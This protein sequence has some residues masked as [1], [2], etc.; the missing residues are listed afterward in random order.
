NH[1]SAMAR[2]RGVA[3]V[4]EQVYR[5][6]SGDWSWRDAMADGAGEAARDLLPGSD[7]LRRLNARPNPTHTKFTVVAGRLSPVSEEDLVLL[8][9]RV[10]E[11]ARS[12]GM[13]DTAGSRVAKS[14]FREA[15]RG[16][17]DGVVSIESAR[18]PDVTDTIVVEANHLSMIVNL[19]PSSSIPP[20]IP[21][22]LERVKN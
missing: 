8:A 18:L 1:G 17:G 20:A 14:M 11:F 6:L 9:E 7:F 21:I 12:M 10:E 13:E 3:E 16:V 15:V 2:L 5:W 4:R 22:V 19:F